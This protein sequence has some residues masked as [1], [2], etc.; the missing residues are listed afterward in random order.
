[1]GGLRQWMP[2]THWTF[3][4]ATLAIAGLPPLSGFFSKDEILWK[5][6][7]SAHGSPVLWAVGALGAGLTAF[8]MFRLVFMTFYGTCRA[9]KETQQHLHESPN[10]MTVPLI[11]LAFLAVIGG[12]IGIPAALGGGNQFEHFLAPVF[13]SA[14]HAAAAAHGALAHGAEALHGAAGAADAHGAAAGAAAAVHGAASH[15]HDPLEY[16]LMAISVGI[17]LTGITLAHRMYIANPAIPGRLAAGARG[18][19]QTLYNKYWVDEAYFAT[20]VAGI[21]GLSRFLALFDAYVV[22]GIV[23]GMGYLTRA[24]AWV[25]GAID[26]YIV[27]GMVNGVAGVT[28]LFGGGMS[29]LQSGVIQ[30]YVFA[31]FGGLIVLIVIMRFF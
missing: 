20:V 4:I 22:D 11:A 27:D 17:A 8:Y 14:P 31:V 29:R 24:A 1:M 30:N 26:K 18:I 19:Y 28:K 6:W 9:D 10:S 21:Q 5:A 7:S 16:I 2:R 15:G 13:E 23:N 12:W 25:G 3:L